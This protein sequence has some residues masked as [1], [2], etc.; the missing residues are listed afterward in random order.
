MEM[1]EILVEEEVVK[2]VQVEGEA[3]ILERLLESRS[4]TGTRSRCSP[5]SS[6]RRRRKISSTME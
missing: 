4:R 6:R 2:E 3:A 1:M 5:R